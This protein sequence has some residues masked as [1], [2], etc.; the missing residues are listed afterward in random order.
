VA[1]RIRCS[2]LLAQAVLSGC[3]VAIAQTKPASSRAQA[4]TI[5]WD[6]LPRAC[7]VPKLC[8]RRKIYPICSQNG[9][10]TTH[11]DDA[12]KLKG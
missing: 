10:L 9:V 6:G 7:G 1:G 12:E 5:F 2:N 4:T 11:T 3:S 8:S